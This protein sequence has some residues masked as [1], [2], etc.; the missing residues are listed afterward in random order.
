[1]RS[2][3]AGVLCELRSSDLMVTAPTAS[4]TELVGILNHEHSGLGAFLRTGY[5]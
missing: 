2:R 3:L 4:R 5:G 1:M